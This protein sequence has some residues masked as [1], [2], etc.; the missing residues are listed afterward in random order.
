MMAATRGSNPD[1][2]DGRVSQ[3]RAFRV[4]CPVLAWCSTMGRIWRISFARL[5]A[6]SVAD[7]STPNVSL[8]AHRHSAGWL[9]T[10]ETQAA[11]PPRDPALVVTAPGFRR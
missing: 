6:L 7:V 10:L 3:G 8:S 2:A 9:P 5:D 1:P 4:Q 11:W